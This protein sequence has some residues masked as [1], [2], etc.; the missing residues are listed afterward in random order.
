MALLKAMGSPLDD[1]TLTI[2]TLSA[3]FL[4]FLKISE[5]GLVD[6]RVNQVVSLLLD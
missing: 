2:Q 5:R 3:T 4:P 1:P 6:T